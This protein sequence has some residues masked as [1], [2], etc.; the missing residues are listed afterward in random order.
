MKSDIYNEIPLGPPQ[1]CNLGT[2]EI[3]DMEPNNNA[4]VAPAD[5]TFAQAIESILKDASDGG[6]YVYE[7]L[8]A[9]LFQVR[10]Q[11]T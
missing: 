5:A 4:P 6:A 10:Q 2:I 8:R 3:Q 11:P 7:E 1:V 9:Q